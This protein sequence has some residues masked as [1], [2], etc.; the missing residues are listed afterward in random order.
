LTGTA[1]QART[2]GDALLSLGR[3]AEAAEMYRLALTRV[4]ED[5]EL[6][7]TRLGIALARAG[8]RAEAEAAFRAVT[9]SRAELAALWQVWLARP[10]A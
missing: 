2:A 1:T 7:N 3:N 8:Q 9:G 5:P 10:S 4:G 6:V